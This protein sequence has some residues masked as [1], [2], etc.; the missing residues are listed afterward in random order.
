ME[1]SDKQQSL[2]TGI[3]I[4]ARSHEQLDAAGKTEGHK[5]SIVITCAGHVLSEASYFASEDFI[6]NEIKAIKKA[7]REAKVTV[8]FS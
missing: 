2:N 7:I 6:R 3:T 5:Y 1:M 4:S 8:D